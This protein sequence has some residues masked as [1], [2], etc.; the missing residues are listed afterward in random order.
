VSYRKSKNESKWK[1]RRRFSFYSSF[2][3]SLAIYKVSYRKI[4]Q[5]NYRKRTRTSGRDG[6]RGKVRTRAQERDEEHAS[7]DE[8]RETERKRERERERERARERRRT[9]NRD[10]EKERKT[11]R[12][13][14]KEMSTYWDTC[15]VGKRRRLNLFFWDGGRSRFSKEGYISIL[16][17]LENFIHMHTR[18][19]AQAIACTKHTNAYIYTHRYMCG[20]EEKVVSLKKSCDKCA[21]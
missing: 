15:L 2:Y 10:R 6:E 21:G 3:S 14:E 9:R 4:W 19:H 16:K 5:V 1:R 12:E 8:E 13:R 7:R 20:L 17:I 18:K 11:E